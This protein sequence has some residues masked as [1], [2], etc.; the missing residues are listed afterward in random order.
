VTV[1]AFALEI[2]NY[3]GSLVEVD[4]SAAYQVSEHFGIGG[5]L[6]YFNLRLDANSDGGGGASFE[7]QFF[8][9]AIFGYATF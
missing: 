7:Y 8:G 6:K 5:G 1:L 4:A 3:G 9:P 2:D